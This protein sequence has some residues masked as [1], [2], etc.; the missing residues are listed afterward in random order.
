MEKTRISSPAPQATHEARGARAAAGKAGAAQAHDQTGAQTA[1]FAL[2]LAALEGGEGAGVLTTALDG[3]GDDAEELLGDPADAAAQP[4]AGQPDAAALAAWV[5]GLQPGVA[6]AKAVEGVADGMKGSTVGGVAGNAMGGVMGGEADTLMGRVGLGLLRHGQDSLV[7]QTALLDGAAETA[8]LNGVPQGPAG[9]T[10]AARALPA[11]QALAVQDAAGAGGGHRA[12]R[13]VAAPAQPAMEQLAAQAVPAAQ[14]ASAEPAGRQDALQALA[15]A[16]A[17]PESD[18]VVSAMAAGAMAGAAAG[19]APAAPRE[20]ESRIAGAG[21]TQG[22]QPHAPEAAAD[23]EQA[24]ADAAQS[25]MGSAEDQLA[26]QVAY[27]VHH[28]T[29]NAAL[30][31]DG[32]GRSVEVRVAL[33]GDEAHVTFRSDQAEARQLLDTGSAE[34][35]GMLQREGLHLAGVTVGTAG[36]DGAPARQGAREGGRQDARQAT[37]Q[38]AAPAGGGAA[39]G[40]GAGTRSVDIFV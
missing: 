31:L 39:Q 6:L 18:P 38:A 33:T 9:R 40:R 25:G 8:A 14:A 29:Q 20:G 17:R 12:L 36:G 35:R 32:D 7:G 34:L 30:T 1:G 4:L 22:A 37:V 21:E 19:A 2:L 3:G 15:P 16:L 5:A 23:A 13:A 24:P 10:G 27:W 11:G 26:E 28:K